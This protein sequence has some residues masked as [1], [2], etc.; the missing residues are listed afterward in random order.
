MYVIKVITLGDFFLPSIFGL[1]G[2]PC[3][4]MSCIEVFPQVTSYFNNIWTDS[5]IKFA[6]AREYFGFM[7]HVHYFYCFWCVRVVLLKSSYI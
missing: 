6:R 7:L 1:L 2:F 3:T 4:E 5:V